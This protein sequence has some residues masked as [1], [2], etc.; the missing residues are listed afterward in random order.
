V[1]LFRKSGDTIA[2]KKECNFLLTSCAL[3]RRV[4][5]TARRIF[6]MA[7]FPKPEAEIAVLG[8][9]LWRGL[10]DNNPHFSQPQL[11]KTA[12]LV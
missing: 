3:P 11:K 2:G 8:E 6:K 7:R 5:G 9:R 12:N 1:F 10:L 4:V